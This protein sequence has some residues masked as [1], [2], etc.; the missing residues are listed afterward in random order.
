MSCAIE[1]HLDRWVCCDNSLHLDVVADT[2]N[3]RGIKTVRVLHLNWRSDPFE[4]FTVVAE[5]DYA[6]NLILSVEQDVLPGV[7]F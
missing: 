6:K 2:L 5:R 7:P 1:V 3:Q 4:V